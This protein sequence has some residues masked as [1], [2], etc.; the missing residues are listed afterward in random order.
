MYYI[1]YNR[2]FLMLKDKKYYVEFI[3]NVK[4]AFADSTKSLYSRSS[5]PTLTPLPNPVSLSLPDMRPLPHLLESLP[6]F[7][8]RAEP[9]HLPRLFEASPAGVGGFPTFGTR[10]RKS[11]PSRLPDR[12]DSSPHLLGAKL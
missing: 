6:S 11:S 2:S 12:S 4:I 9:A 10:R 3:I 7:A 8:S 5:F 1:I